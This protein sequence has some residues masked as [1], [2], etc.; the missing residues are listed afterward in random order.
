[1]GCFFVILKKKL[2][3]PTTERVSMSTQIGRV[4]VGR[5]DIAL[6]G[7]ESHRFK[8]VESKYPCHL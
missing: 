7:A 4:T 2:R 6:A 3:V 5:V 8:V 1:M